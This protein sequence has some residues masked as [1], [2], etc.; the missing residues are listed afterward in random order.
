MNKETKK[1]ELRNY[2]IDFGVCI[3]CGNCVEYC[4]TNCLSMTEEYELATFD[5]HNLNIDNIA[6]GRLPTN[7]TTDP[8]VKPLRELTYLPK[9]VMDPHEIPASDTRV[10]KL[11]EEVY[12]W[13]RPESNE[14][15]DK[16]PNPNN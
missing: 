4:P 9:G 11:P 2:S 16:V 1:K 14:N 12:D 10:G 13:M 5:R 6:L 8:S 3:F 7:V 15:K